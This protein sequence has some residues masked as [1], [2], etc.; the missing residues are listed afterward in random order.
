MDD[1]YSIIEKPEPQYELITDGEG[2]VWYRAYG[3][4][5]HWTMNEI[6]DWAK[7]HNYEFVGEYNE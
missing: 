5:A 4:A 3:E 7:R 1:I 6:K 2:K